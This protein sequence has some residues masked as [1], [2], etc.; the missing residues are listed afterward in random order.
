[1]GA[2]DQKHAR[3]GI[4]AFGLSIITIIINFV[5]IYAFEKQIHYLDN[6]EGI[7]CILGPIL[8]LIALFLAMY[9]LATE[10]RNRIFAILAITLSILTG[11]VFFGYIFLS[12]LS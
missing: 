6:L 5:Y 3:M 12:I 9:S 4:L 11:V 8:S 1:M 7:L 10:N 2:V